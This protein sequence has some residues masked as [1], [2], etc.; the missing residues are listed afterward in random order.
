MIQ[1]VI[2]DDDDDFCRAEKELVSQVAAACGEE[3][4]IELYT[5][6]VKL[7]ERLERE[8]DQVDILILD[9]DMPQ[10]NGYQLAEFIQE[11]ERKL[12]LIFLSAQEHLVFQA[13]EYRPFRFVRKSQYQLELRLALQKAFA[14]WKRQQ[15]RRLRIRSEGAERCVLHSEIRY[16]VMEKRKLVL[17]LESGER[18]ET[19]MTMK[20]LE[21]KLS[22]EHF[23]KI[24]SG[25][26][27][28]SRY[29][30]SCTPKVITLTDDENLPVS[31]TRWKE[32]H[33]RLCK[34]WG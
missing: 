2:C 28:N 24:N 17:Y 32:V 33:F 9:I 8:K 22:D 18:L 5:D 10:I 23:L 3:A 15:D 16:G 1:I 27:V 25:C 26:L 34:F 11:N 21:E 19:R 7:K 12:L 29:V 30:K 20:E 6:S 13:F 31:R 14:Q 4:W